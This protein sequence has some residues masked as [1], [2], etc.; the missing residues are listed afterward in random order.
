MKTLL[1]A[2]IHSNF[3]A[4]QAVLHET[5][6]ETFDR[7]IFSGDLVDYGLDPEPCVEWCFE[8]RAV[9]VRGNHDHA[10][11]QRIRAK[12][13][14]GFRALAAATRPAHWSLM[15]PKCLKYLGRLPVTQFERTPEGT[16]FVI[17]G[18][19][20]DPLDEYLMADPSGWSSRLDGIEADFVIVGHTHV[21]FDIDADGTRVI[22]PGSVGQPRDGVPGAAYA[23]LEDD[24]V[25]FRRASYD[26]DLAV[27]AVRKVASEQW[28]VDLTDAL[29]RRGGAVTRD[30]MN[31][32]S[33][34]ARNG[35]DSE[36]ETIQ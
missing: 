26:V 31:E 12:G 32:I 23:V 5:R 4:L 28:I 27:D 17:H 7:I 34:A 10:V 24:V 9:A 35:T 16:F 3:V 15:S 20:R 1:L 19:P 8:S 11:A 29:L 2:D 30:E 14:S 6:N 25:D 22:N 33:G 21:Q 18:T 13:G 36:D